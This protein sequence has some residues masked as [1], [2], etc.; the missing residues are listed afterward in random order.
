MDENK[1]RGIW[2]S[3][4]NICYNCYDNVKN[5]I[6]GENTNEIIYCSL[7]ELYHI[8]LTH[9]YSFIEIKE[10]ISDK[11]SFIL[12]VAQPDDEIVLIYNISFIGDNININKRTEIRNVN[13]IINRKNIMTYKDDILYIACKDSIKLIDINEASIINN[14]LFE[15]ISYINLYRNDFLLCGINKNK[16]IYNFEGKL[17]QFEIKQ[18]ELI[19]LYINSQNGHEGSIIDSLIFY[20]NN[21]EYIIALGTDK[22]ITITHSFYNKNIRQ[23]LEFPEMSKIHDNNSKLKLIELV[24]Y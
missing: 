24:D 3:I 5:I 10:K 9:T 21:E 11:N 18:N 23:E 4:A 12:A 2:D 13:S 14:V 17:I 8:D 6:K 16:S 15:N 7:K 19:P 20:K 1:K 22:K